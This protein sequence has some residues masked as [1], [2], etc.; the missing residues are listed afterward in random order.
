[1]LNSEFITAL[2]GLREFEVID[3]EIESDATA[4]IQTRVKWDVGICPKCKGVC[5]EVV[6]SVERRTRDL[7]ISGRRVLLS[8]RQRRFYCYGC[9]SSFMEKLPSIDC[10]GSHYTKRYE[11]YVTI[12]VRDS[13]IKAVA[14]REKLSWETIKRI[15]ERVA[16]REGLFDSPEVVRWVSFDEIALKKRHK[17]FS[18]IIGSPEEGRVL[19]LLEGRTKEQLLK[20]I[21]KSWTKEQREQVEVVTLDMWDGYFYAAIEAFPNAILV[22]DRF[23][24][25]K[26]LLDAISKLRRQIQKQL[27]EEKRKELKGVRWL[28]VSN[29][30]DLSEEKKK[31]LDRALKSCPE[32][33]LCHYVKEEFRDW[34]EEEQEVEEAEHKLE[35]WM[36]LAESLGSQAMNNFVKTLKNWKEPIVNYFE[37][38]ASNGFAEGLNNALQLLKRRAFGF[39]NFSN[40]RLRALLLHAFP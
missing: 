9:E 10:V 31:E 6:E 37:E 36:K 35:Q 39:R 18:L 22:I 20:W 1:M 17:L 27:S 11:E 4:V 24:V 16:V 21:Y 26:N 32:L 40:F 23:H 15:V 19:D 2:I 28:L 7:S 34:Y 29:Y 3:A 5:H 25:E 30:D 38:R 14:I 33:A 13:T 12:L 8:Y